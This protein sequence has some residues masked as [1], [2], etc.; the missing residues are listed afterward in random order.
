[1]NAYIT[2]TGVKGKITNNPAA[3]YIKGP[4]KQH[5]DG[6]QAVAYARLRYMDDDFSRTRRQ[7]EVI[8]QVLEK[9]KKAD[10]VT[11]T[12]II[13]TVLPQLAFNINAGDLVQLAK[14]ISRYN[15]VG[16]EGFPKD[17]KTQMMGKKG[18]CVIPTSLAS[19]VTWA[20]SFLFGD[21]DYNPSDA[22]WTYSESGR[23]AEPIGAEAR[24]RRTGGNPAPE[25][26]RRRRSRSTGRTKR[27]KARRTAGRQ[28]AGAA[29]KAPPRPIKTIKT[30]AAAEREAGSQRAGRRM[31][32][33]TPEER[34]RRRTA[35]PRAPQRAAVLHR[36]RRARAQARTDRRAAPRTEMR[37]RARPR[38]GRRRAAVPPRARS[39]VR[40][41]RSRTTPPERKQRA[42]RRRRARRRMIP[43]CRRT[44]P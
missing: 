24:R 38:A 28:R 14:G 7:R 40:R 30:E 44:A 12:S 23:T 37:A 35:L 9:A 6:L 33:R 16:S 36:I 10:L 4:G 27:S 13:D 39:P 43:L 26:T 25:G 32:R 29:G 1:M 8:S 15:I 21:N 5:L 20:H 42:Q 34:A 41:R 19:N 2:E 22:V 18:D 3:E 11:L 17:L 31:L